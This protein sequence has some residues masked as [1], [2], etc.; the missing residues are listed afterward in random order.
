MKEKAHK[1][2]TVISHRAWVIT[3]TVAMNCLPKIASLLMILLATAV[4]NGKKL[5]TKA[6]NLGLRTLK[7]RTGVLCL[8]TEGGRIAAT[9]LAGKAGIGSPLG[10]GRQWVPWIHHQDVVRYVPVWA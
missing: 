10:T 8:T 4:L 6:S 2:H 9:G 3:V 5:L 1:V 7:F